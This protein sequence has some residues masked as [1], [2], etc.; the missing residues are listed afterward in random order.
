M[1]SIVPD[2]VDEMIT[3]FQVNGVMYYVGPHDKHLRYEDV[4]TK[5]GIC[6]THFEE[7]GLGA[8]VF[9]TFHTLSSTMIN[10]PYDF[11]GRLLGSISWTVQT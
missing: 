9:K 1:S 10:M 2:D 7:V 4:L 5:T 6:R 8:D 3:D 11:S